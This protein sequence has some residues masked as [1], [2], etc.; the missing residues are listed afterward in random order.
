MKTRGLTEGFGSAPK[1]EGKPCIQSCCAQ[2]TAHQC[3]P[4][5]IFFFHLKHFIYFLHTTDISLVQIAITIL[6]LPVF[7][8]EIAYIIFFAN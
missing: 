7:V 4:T 3:E 8:G 5:L 2:T 1:C 6:K